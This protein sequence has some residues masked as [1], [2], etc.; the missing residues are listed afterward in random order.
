M[1]NNLDYKSDGNQRLAQVLLASGR[2]IGRPLNLL[3]P[4]EV[5]SSK[6]HLSDKNNSNSSSSSVNSKTDTVTVQDPIPSRPVRRAA[7]TARQKF[8]SW[9]S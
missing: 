4:I 2:V 9:L 6:D 8:K 5:S 7:E 1:W 3:Y